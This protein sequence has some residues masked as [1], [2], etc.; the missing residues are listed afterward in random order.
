MLFE[1]ILEYQKK[2]LYDKSDKIRL[3]HEYLELASEFRTSFPQIKCNVQNL[4][5]GVKG[6]SVFRLKVNSVKNVDEIVT[7]LN[8][9]GKL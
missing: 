7:E 6:G 2:G 9:F 1:H 8:M 3:I 4:S 5:S